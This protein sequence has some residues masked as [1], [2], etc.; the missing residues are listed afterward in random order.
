M[1]SRMFD[2]VAYLLSEVVRAGLETGCLDA[3]GLDGATVP[4][5]LGTMGFDELYDLA[6]RVDLHHR[7]APRYA[8]LFDSDAADAT[9]KSYSSFGTSGN[10]GSGPFSTL[11]LI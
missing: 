7:E 10:S 6:E 4:E 1:L 2:S 9:D 3:A 8:S 5:S 11:C